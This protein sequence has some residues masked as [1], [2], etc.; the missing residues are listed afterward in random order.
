MYKMLPL[1]N[2][3]SY[4]SPEAYAQQV[5]AYDITSYKM[6]KPTVSGNDTVIVAE[7]VTPQMPISYTWTFAKVGSTWYVKSRTMGGTVP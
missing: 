1:E 7:Q 3:K 6:G 2:Q 5:K 4:G